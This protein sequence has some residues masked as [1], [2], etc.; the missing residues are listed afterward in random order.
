MPVSSYLQITPILDEIIRLNPKTIMDVGCGL[1]IY[2]ALCRV[3][4]EGDNLYD[5]E[6]LT[7]NKKENWKVKIDCIEGF[8][9]YITDLHRHVYNNIYIGDAQEV[10]KDI[11]NAYDLVLAIDIIEHF[12]KI[13]GRILLRE[14]KRIGR[15]VI[16]ATPIK[17]EEQIIPENPLE[18]HRSC[19]SKEEL[20]SLGFNIVKEHLS[21]IGLYQ[22]SAKHT[23]S[24]RTDNIVRLYQEGDEYG[25]V[26]LFKEIFGREMTLDEWRWKYTGRGNKKVYSSVAVNECGEV[27]AHYGGIP[28]RMTYQGKEVYGLA[29]GDV[30][31]HPKFR[32]LKLFKKAAI[33]VPEDAVKDGIILGY[34]FP[35]EKSMALPEK[36]G[37]YEKVEDVFEANKEANFINNLSRF[38]YKFF[39]LSYDDSRID[40]L[41]ESVKRGIKIGIVRDRE[42]LRWRYQRHPFYKYEL[43][44]LKKRWGNKLAGLAVLRREGERI[45]VI[46]FVCGKDILTTLF[47]KIEN[48]AY[49]SRI[50]TIT[51]WFP[52]YLRKIME[53]MGFQ[54]KISCTCIPR[55]T[56]EKTL[57]KEEIKGKFFYTMGDTDFM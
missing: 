4:L 46:D 19:W 52:E 14:L 8:D 45:L 38:I 2:G 57:T 32:G 35:N 17:P 26:K 42:Y 15:S 22:C 53:D 48:Y 13:S 16:I 31:V 11:K 36:I 39:P 30:M 51:L 21:L 12:D 7:W 29:I 56:H 47:K 44:G 37:L 41:W 49:T 23:T 5:R 34:G 9:K 6:N 20:L 33:L 50:K 10:I 28:H 43:W 18:N 3:Y 40:I 55:T 54:T 24:P 25:I 1:G 27:V